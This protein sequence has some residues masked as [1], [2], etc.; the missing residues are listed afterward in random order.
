MLLKNLIYILQ[1]ENYY[2]GRFL[3]FAYSHPIWWRLEQ[4]QKITWTHKV[5]LIYFLSWVL[6]ILAFSLVRQ[7]EGSFFLISKNFFISLLVLILIILSLPLIISLSFLIISPLDSLFK[8]IIIKKARN[9]LKNLDIIKIGITGSFGKTS[10]KE[11]L[12]TILS[13]EFKVIK[14]PDNINTDI[15]IAIFIMENQEKI[16]ES[17]VFVIEMGAYQQGEIR[18]TAEMINPEYSL[19]TGINEC[20]LERFGSLENIINTKLELANIT[21]K[22][23]IVNNDN[24]NISQIN[25]KNTQS[26]GDFLKI[27]QKL[28]QNIKILDNFSGLNFEFQN[29]QFYTKLLA[30][31]NIVLILMCIKIAIELGI[32]LEKIKKGV[33]EIK[34]IPH[35]LEPIYNPN[36]KVMV[37]DDSYNGNFAGIKSGL[38]I[39]AQSQGR[40]IV[41]TQGLVEL[42][43]EAARIHNDIGELYAGQ[44]DLALLIKNSVCDYIVEGLKSRGFTNYKIY[45]NTEEAHKDLVNVLQKNDTIIFQNDWTDNYN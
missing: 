20:H 21:K 4:R 2:L 19:L 39:L 9:I 45:K 32:D 6:I 23:T 25:F 12:A 28:A 31:H 42:G 15:G 22:L 13:Q 14:T 3:K 33:A 11:I 36:T 24:A 30:R 34:Y 38:E 17:E 5:K 37:I 41:L 35:R 29:T 26:K 10:T 40:K 43:D 1:S 16:K 27:S 8:K 7:L 44:V 18:S